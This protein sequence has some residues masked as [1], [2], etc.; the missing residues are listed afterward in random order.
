MVISFLVLR[1]AAHGS[2]SIGNGAAKKLG[3]QGEMKD[4]RNDGLGIIRFH[5][6]GGP[7]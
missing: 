2:L 3:Y 5:I 4:S 7:F 6:K 1:T